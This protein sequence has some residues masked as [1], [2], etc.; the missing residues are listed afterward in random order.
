MEIH[1]PSCGRKYRIPDASAGKRARCANPACGAI[2][3]ARPAEAD[4]AARSPRP[5]A[6]ES[7]H[8]GLPNEVKTPVP[9]GAAQS[10]RDALKEHA[11]GG[12]GG[13][14]KTAVHGIVAVLAVCGVAGMLLG[15]AS[16]LKGCGRGA[17]FAESGA[18]EWA[19]WGNLRRSG[20]RRLHRRGKA[21]RGQRRRPVP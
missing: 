13:R 4:S 21:Q 7:G 9:P 19:G 6:A 5:D 8:R 20:R 2:F 16:L 1:C 10:A 15:L 3:T 12:R 18:L 11:R 14:K 17:T